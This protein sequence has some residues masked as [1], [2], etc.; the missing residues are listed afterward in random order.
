MNYLQEHYPN[1]DCTKEGVIYR[2]GS[3]LKSFK[4]NNYRQ[5][6]LFDTDG[7]RKTCGVH[8]VVAMKYLDYFE[9][10]VVHHKDGNTL[11][12]TIENL[13]VLS[14]SE[15]SRKHVLQSGNTLGNLMRGKIPWNK[16]MKMSKEFC[17]KCSKSAKRRKGRKFHGNQYVNQDKIRKI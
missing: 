14:S 17:E 6:L 11:N 10:C 7:K 16:G 3:I 8:V 13:E 9:G 15:H 4:S 12:N 2:N 1:Y 5:V